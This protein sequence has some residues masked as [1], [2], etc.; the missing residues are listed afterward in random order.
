M[1]LVEGDGFNRRVYTGLAPLQ[2]A[3]LEPRALRPLYREAAVLAGPLATKER[4][5]AVLNAADVIHITAH[6]EPDPQQVGATAFILAPDAAGAGT[7]HD[8]LLTISDIEASR[9]PHPQV[10]VLAACATAAALPSS[11]GSLSLA[12][13]FL[14][15]GVP[16]V[17]A[18]LW[19]I[20]D[21]EATD[22]L[23]SFHRRLARGEAAVNALRE[24]QLERLRQGR[25]RTSQWAAYEVLGG[26]TGDAA[27]NQGRV[28]Q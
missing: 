9:L 17:V 20:D 7:G 10:A 21:R 14:A 3:Q 15:A 8:S 19:P 12:R 4:T 2:A 25:A 16:A 1:L 6:T 5:L 23:H 24:A 22:L 28:L 26:V 18:T 27:L 13:S 11:E